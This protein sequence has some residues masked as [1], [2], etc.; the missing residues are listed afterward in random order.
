MPKKDHFWKEKSKSN[1]YST[2]EDGQQLNNEKLQLGCLMRIADATEL[3]AKNH[4]DLYL[5]AQKYKAIAMQNAQR[6][7]RLENMLRTWKGVAT[8][9]KNQLE[10]KPTTPDQK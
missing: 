2:L 1:W 10:K 4:N 5:E 9:Y 3:M 6:A 8:R 7:E